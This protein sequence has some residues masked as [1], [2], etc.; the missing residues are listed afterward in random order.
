MP[1]SYKARIR[2]G[3]QAP[4]W[5][6]CCGTGGSRKQRSLTIT[7]KPLSLWSTYRYGLNRI[8][9]RLFGKGWTYINE[10]SGYTI[11]TVT[12]RNVP[13]TKDGFV[14]PVPEWERDAMK[15]IAEL[16]RSA[17]KGPLTLRLYPGSVLPE[18]PLDE[19]VSA[20]VLRYLVLR[21]R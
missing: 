14:N 17:N 10:P 15:I 2:Y 18:E 21:W 3:Y 13:L 8:R 6:P 5:S 16:P 12:Y 7:L 9:R 1:T 19:N 11:G 20:K 4:V